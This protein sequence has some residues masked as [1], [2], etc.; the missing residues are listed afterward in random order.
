MDLNRE[1]SSALDNILEILLLKNQDIYELM[2]EVAPTTKEFDLTKLL[3]FLQDEKMINYTIH[4]DVTYY[5]IE[6]PGKKTI[7]FGGYSKQWEELNNQRQSLKISNEALEISKKAL[8]VSKN[9]ICISVVGAMLVIITI[10][11]T[12]L[13]MCNK[14]N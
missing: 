14:P 1:Y 12:I 11:L 13:D 2:D 7:Q 4:K 10:I 8:T 9:N 6:N 5:R 3:Q